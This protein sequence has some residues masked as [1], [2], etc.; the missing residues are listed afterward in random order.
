MYSTWPGQ[1]STLIDKYINLEGVDKSYG[2][3]TAQQQ[4]LHNI[5]LSVARGERVAVLGHSG[6]GKSTLLNV[7]SG[8]DT[9][10]SGTVCISDTNLTH[11]SEKER[12]LFR[13]RN[14]GFVYQ[15]F[16]LIP[17]L[18]ALENIQLPLQLNNY[19]PTEIDSQAHA[20][21]SQVGLSERADAYPDELS[22]GEQQRIAIARAMVHSPA[23]VLADEHTGNLDADTGR[24]MMELFNDI[25][26]ATGQTVLM[27]T[28]SMAVA[29]NADRVIRFNDGKL[30]TDDR[31][32]ESTLAW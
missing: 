30:H 29:K 23:L 10:D 22:G 25:A 13:R 19:T 4:V 14:I 17:T 31:F 21:L 6:C 12:T 32:D 18:T 3:D 7:I 28:H 20:M 8:I 15:S 26:K 27:V 9:V 24:Q 5:N 11:L 2:K 16:N 1:H